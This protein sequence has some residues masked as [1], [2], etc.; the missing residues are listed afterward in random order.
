MSRHAGQVGRLVGDDADGPAAQAREADDDVRRVVPVHL[1]EVPVVGDRVDDV[2]HVVRLVR[3][4]R[5]ERVERGVLAIGGIVGGHPRRVVEVVARAGS[6]SSSR[7]SARHSRSFSAAKCATPLRCVVRHRAAEVLLG[8]VLVGHRLDDVGPGDEHVAGALH[9]DVEVGDRRRVDRAAGAGPHD[10]GDLRH[11]AR[12]QRVAQEDVGVAAQRHDAFLDAR[13][14]RVVQAD[15]RR[16]HA[17]RQV[18]HLADLGGVGLGERTAEHRE[19][20]RERVDLPAVDRPVARDDAVARH[21]LVLHAEVAAAV[22]HQL[23]ELLEGARVEQGLHA[24]ARRQLPGVAVALEP[25][26]AAAQLRPPLEVRQLFGRGRH[27]AAPLAAAQSFRNRSMPRSVSG[28]LK[29]ASMTD[30][31]ARADVG[32][33]AGRRHHVH[34]VP[35]ARHEHLGLER[36]VPVD[37]DNLLD[38]LHAV[39]G[40]VVEPAD[41]RAHEGGAGLG[42]EQ[43]LRRREHQR[44]VHL[45]ALGAQR[46]A[47]LHARLAEG[48]LD[49]HVRVD[50]RQITP[51]ANHPLDVGGDDFGADRALDDLAD[52]LR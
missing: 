40:D 2:V 50:G 47:R 31:R 12:G 45:D 8:H 1:E 52:P 34:R 18:H 44:D 3:R 24:L 11:H 5:H 13:A 27:C 19:V 6:R 23:V 36:V 21:E 49:H 14:A 9:H 42:G 46:L 20:L 16:A 38:E 10:G 33:H 41:E 25:V 32:A 7:M 28:C 48:D 35:G 29:S 37:L 17:H 26:L 51:L 15:D 4:G 22:R 39:G 30:G 43:R